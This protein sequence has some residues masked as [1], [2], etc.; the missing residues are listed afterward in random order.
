M[1]R[2]E[3]AQTLPQA[4]PSKRGPWHLLWLAVGTTALGLLL[5]VLGMYL[6]AWSSPDL[7]SASLSDY[8]W[9]TPMLWYLNLLP[10]VILIWLFYFLLGRCWLAYLASALPLLG[11]TAAN[12]YKIQLRGDPLLASDLALISEA[13][14]MAGKYTLELTDPIRTVLLWAAAGLLLALL[15][16]PRRRTI[17]RDLRL[18]GLFSAIAVAATAFGGLYCNE[19]LYE[20]TQAGEDLVNP[21]IDAEAYLSHGAAYAFLYTVQDLVPHPPERYDPQAAQAIL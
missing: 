14:D 21:W 9:D 17:R 2:L 3:P 1:N 20:Q 12:Y 16:L 10:G 6:S 8:Y 4:Q 18:F 7:S 13:G 19:D 11:L 15:L 5:G